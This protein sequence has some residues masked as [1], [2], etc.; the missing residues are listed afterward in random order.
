MSL[1]GLLSREKIEEHLKNSLMLVTILNTYI[2]YDK[3]AQ[4]AKKA[5][6]EDLSLKEAAVRLGYLSPKEFDKIVRPELML[7]PRKSK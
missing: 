1:F 6:K 7:G 4:I 3:A 5:H 2:G